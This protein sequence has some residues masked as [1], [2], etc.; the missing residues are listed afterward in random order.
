MTDTS[1]VVPIQSAAP[2]EDAFAGPPAVEMMGEQPGAPRPDAARIARDIL[3]LGAIGADPTGGV[4]RLAFTEQERAAHKVLAEWLSAAGLSVRVDAIGNTIGERRGSAGD[5][6]HITIGS[7]LDTV[8]HGGAFDG[9]AGVV[10]AVE[11]ARMLDQAGMLTRHPLRV[12]AFAGQEGARFG[13]GSLGSAAVVGALDAGDV[14]ALVDRSG[15]TL[16]QAARSLGFDPARFSDARWSRDQVA[17]YLELQAE[18]GPVLERADTQIGI[19]DA[20]AGHT[21]LRISVVGQAN[22]AGAATMVERRDALAAAAEITLA[23]ER[24]AL[25]HQ[26]AAAAATVGQLEVSPNT[27]ATVPGRVDFTV[28]VRDVDADR[29]RDTA[30]SIIGACREICARRQ[31]ALDVAVVA[32][33]PPAVLPLWLRRVAREVCG[34]LALTHRMMAGGSGHDVQMLS[35]LAPAALLLVPSRDGRGHSPAEWTSATQIAR[36][37]SALYAMLMRI[38][39]LLEALRV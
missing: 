17:A 5:L 28:D 37:T 39:E 10:A 18:Q 7:H 32:D 9:A 26:S 35:R 24:F 14:E 33:A 15:V 13:A 11:V 29:Q 20:T 25:E 23:V 16:A 6:P 36:G 8:A 2:A 3:C 12:V 27:A 1:P 34:D 22:H 31:V 30:R 21:R 19:V 4:T 38:D